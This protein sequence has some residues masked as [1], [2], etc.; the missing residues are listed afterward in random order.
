MGTIKIKRTSKGH[1][2]FKARV[3]INGDDIRKSF[4]TEQEAQAWI[5]TMEAMKPP[6]QPKG[7]RSVDYTFTNRERWEP[8][9]FAKAFGIPVATMEYMIYYKNIN[10]LT[11]CGAVT[12]LSKH[13]GK[14]MIEK[15]AMLRWIEEHQ[16]KRECEGTHQFL[17]TQKGNQNSCEEINENQDTDPTT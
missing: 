9:A 17:Y 15:S 16:L 8:E 5:D 13:S 14:L 12:R 11:A 2:R 6:P 4:D 3:K 1:A 10:G 7:Q